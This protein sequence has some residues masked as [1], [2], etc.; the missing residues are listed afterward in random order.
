MKS[1][2]LCLLFFFLFS[3][4]SYSLPKCEGDER[5]W[6]SCNGTYTWPDGHQYA[7]NQYIGEFKNGQPHG[8]GTMTFA[9]GY[10]Y[11]GE[12]KDGMA[13]GKGTITY[14]DEGKYEGELY[15]GEFKDNRYHG[16]GTLTSTDGAKYVGE[17]KD[18]RYHGKGEHTFPDGSKYVGEYKDGSYHGKGEYTFPDGENYI[19][20]FKDNR[21]HGKGEHTFPDGE[22][23]IGEFKDGKRHGEGTYT[24]ANG[25]KYEG[26]WKDGK[27]HG[28]G[29]YTFANSD[30]GEVVNGIFKKYNFVLTNNVQ[31]YEESW[32]GFVVTLKNINY[33]KYKKRIYKLKK[34][35][36]EVDDYYDDTCKINI[37][38][39]S[40]V[41]LRG[42]EIYNVSIDGGNGFYYVYKDIN[43]DRYI[44]EK[45]KP[46]NLI[47]GC[48]KLF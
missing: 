20:E 47:F 40:Y 8:K 5:M 38:P 13:N 22:N 11:E 45:I 10:K 42:E 4:N 2:K 25:D 6:D 19:G 48:E 29:N 43:Q 14:P 36:I 3:I 39:G 18:N 41:Y 34:Y 16:K 44:E 30:K 46:E 1:L 27:R 21:Y 35:F 26:E 7:D 9:D 12:W 17:F 33:I 37:T 31:G 24:F 32:L 15:E 23:Y 28:K